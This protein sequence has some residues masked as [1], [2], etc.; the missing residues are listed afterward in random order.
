M[1]MSVGPCTEETEVS[2]VDVMNKVTLLDFK[3]FSQLLSISQAMNPRRLLV[4]ID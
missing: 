2:W 4:G 1:T 3:P